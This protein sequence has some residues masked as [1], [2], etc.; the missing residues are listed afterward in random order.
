MYSSS[1]TFQRFGKK[2]SQTFGTENQQQYLFVFSLISVIKT[3]RNPDGLS[4]IDDRNEEC[5]ELSEMISV[6][7]HRLTGNIRE[8]R[9]K[10]PSPP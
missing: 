8:K 3:M 7:S 9:L 6:R 10:A 1:E 4:D 2:P 5:S